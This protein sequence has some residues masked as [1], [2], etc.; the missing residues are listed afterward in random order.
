M[1]KKCRGRVGRVSKMVQ[2]SSALVEVDEMGRH[3]VYGKVFNFTTKFLVHNEYNSL[4]VGDV[5]EIT[6]CRPISKKKNWKVE[7]ILKSNVIRDKDGV[8]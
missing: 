2:G 7:K 8:I 1:Q 5:V 6:L 3:K 4:K